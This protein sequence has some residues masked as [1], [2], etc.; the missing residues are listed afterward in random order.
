LT[1][2]NFQMA[3][4]LIIDDSAVMRSLLTEFLIEHGHKVQACSDGQEGIDKAQSEKF[5]LCI[6]DIHMPKKN[7]SQVFAEVSNDQPNL[8]FIFTDSMPDGISREITEIAHQAY[9]RKPFDLN[10]LLEMI[11]TLTNSARAKKI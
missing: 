3:R 11:S 4:I 7:G 5:D 1:A 2:S 6:C 9:L 10:Q 8:R